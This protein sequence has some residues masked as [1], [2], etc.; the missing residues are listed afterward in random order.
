MRFYLLTCQGWEEDRWNN[1][2]HM[3]TS[4]SSCHPTWWSRNLDGRRRWSLLFSNYEGCQSIRP[5]EILKSKNKINKVRQDKIDFT[6]CWY[7][8]K[9]ETKQD[10]KTWIPK[11]SAVSALWCRTAPCVP[12][13][14]CSVYRWLKHPVL[15]SKRMSKEFVFYN[16]L[17]TYPQHPAVGGS[18]IAKP[19]W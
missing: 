17:N 19:G 13:K 5:F 8:E 18:R 2:E 3:R 7:F 15:G 9:E 16:V 10:K 4:S 11:H 6:R 14:H 1:P 12:N